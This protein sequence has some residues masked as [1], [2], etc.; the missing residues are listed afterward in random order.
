M[1]CKFKRATKIVYFATMAANPTLKKIWRITKKVFLWLFIGHLL[2]ILFIWVF[3]P[4]ITI[5]QFTSLVT[6]HGLSR[7]YVSLSD[8]SPNVRLAVIASEDQQFL[9]HEGID[10]ESI[11]KAY[12]YNK[13]HTKKRGG[14]TISQQV[15]K[16]VFLWQHGGYFR[17]GLELYFTFIIEKIYSKRRIMELYLNISEMGDGIFGIEAASQHYFKKP[18]KFLTRPEA[19]MIVA[20]LPN[21]KVYTISP[22]SRQVARRYPW[23]LK[24]MNFLD[25]VEDIKDLMNDTEKKEVK[26]PA[27]PEYKDLKKK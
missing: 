10:W 12:E 14:S 13:T 8:I 16:N 7:D 19:A 4:P 2:Y 3:N 25:D 5:T 22:M 23:I 6:G 18:A 24:Q 20:C 11:E 17:K 1:G 27:A 9:E 21:P 15:A 26:K